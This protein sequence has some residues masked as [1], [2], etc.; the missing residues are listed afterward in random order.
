M[1]KSDQ[2]AVQSVKIAKLVFFLAQELKTTVESVRG[3][4]AKSGYI[5]P[6]EREQLFFGRQK[7]L[8]VLDP[9]DRIFSFIHAGWRGRA[10]KEGKQLIAHDQR[11]DDLVAFYKQFVDRDPARQL[12]AIG[13]SVQKR[14]PERL[15]RRPQPVA[16]VH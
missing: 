13:E 10:E 5:C 9:R 11:R 3:C 14:V 2:R 7:V 6:Y 4:L 8:V 15:H 1:T 12:A 16:M